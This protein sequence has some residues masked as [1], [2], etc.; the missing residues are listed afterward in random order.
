[1]ND[2]TPFPEEIID[3]VYVV[4]PAGKLDSANAHALS[5][6]L[7]SR[8]AA[9]HDRLVADL[10]HLAYLSSA[11]FRALLVAA[12]QAQKAKGRFV[13]AGVEGKVRQLFE[14][15]GFLEMFAVYADRDSAI[16]GLGDAG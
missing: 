11:G 4:R 1:M 6:Q 9:G 8:I 2:R 7:T 10:S 16:A 5:E 14:L 13:L 15:S 3:G 12:K